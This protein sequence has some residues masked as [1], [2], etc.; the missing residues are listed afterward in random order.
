[1]FGHDLD[2]VIEMHHRAAGEF[3]RGNLTAELAFIVEVE[4]LKA[5]IGASI[6]PWESIIKK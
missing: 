2:Q 3:V 6:Q 1:M 4:R 5:R